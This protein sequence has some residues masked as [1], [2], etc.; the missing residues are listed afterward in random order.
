[1][2]PAANPDLSTH[3]RRPLGLTSAT[4][5]IIA[6]MIGTGVFTTSGFLLAL[7][8]V[9]LLSAPL[10]QLSG[11]H[12]VGRLV[13]NA[14]GGQRCAEAV[15]AVVAL[16]LVTSVSSLVMA[17]PRVYARMAADGF[18]IRHL[19]G[20][21]G[22]PRAAITFQVAVALVMLWTATYEGLITYIGFTL[23]LS[24]AATV[25]G[26]MVLRR[27]EGPSL[28]VPGWPWVPGVF[29][30]VGLAMTALALQ[31]RPLAS[32]A[33]LGTMA[34]SW[35]GWVVQRRFVKTAQCSSGDR[36][37]SRWP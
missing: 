24:S 3:L 29:V 28:R 16:A 6:S 20:G 19:D 13:A 12:E 30:F 5:L 27:R 15:T 18:L 31:R 22:P 11:Q 33:G 32:L 7:N 1:M 21:G 8:A 14:L 25:L 36:P 10:S 37:S 9:I 34:L 35:L 17:G 26:L 4:A 2:K 23:S